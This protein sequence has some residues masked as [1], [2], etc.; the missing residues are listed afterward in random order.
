M[1]DYPVSNGYLIEMES[2]EFYYSHR[3]PGMLTP[4]YPCSDITGEIATKSIDRFIDR[5]KRFWCGFTP[6]WIAGA[7]ARVGRGEQAYSFLQEFMEVYTAK[8]GGF[9]LNFD[10]AGTGKG[11][12]NN[13]CFTNESNSG[14]CDALLEMLLQSQNG[15]IR[16]F[17]AIPDEWKNVSFTHLRARGAFLVSAV[18]S[19]GN[20]QGLTIENEQ[21]AEVSLQNPWENIPEIITNNANVPLKI[22]ENII[23]WQAAKNTTYTISEQCP[24]RP[25][26]S[27]QYLRL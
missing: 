5:G 3:H 6:V 15:V 1:P 10:Y 7:C 11:I 14:F 19:D 4:I 26:C 18:L 21:D 8:Q 12:S 2:K 13:K 22:V 16:I 9:H 25:L 17:P 23:T 24:S 27:V 20:L